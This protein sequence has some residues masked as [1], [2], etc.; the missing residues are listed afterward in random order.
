MRAAPFGDPVHHERGGFSSDERLFLCG[1]LDGANHRTAPC[2]RNI[3]LS[4]VLPFHSFQVK[5]V[6]ALS[7]LRGQPAA[8]DTF[9]NFKS[10]THRL[11]DP[12]TP[13]SNPP[14]NQHQLSGKSRLSPALLSGLPAKTLKR[15]HVT[16]PYW[17]PVSVFASRTPSPM[18]SA[19]EGRSPA[20]SCALTSAPI[21]V[22]QNQRR[23]HKTT[24]REPEHR[25]P[26]NAGHPST[27]ALLSCASIRVCQH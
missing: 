3:S 11:P 5:F 21:R 15:L 20:H 7:S 14:L 25:D 19:A 23:L 17:S 18:K 26:Q 1:A 4:L 27:P 8:Q 9:T 13:T 10:F 12:A 24:H 6:S 2:I 16:S 22:C